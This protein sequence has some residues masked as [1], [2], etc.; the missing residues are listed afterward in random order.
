LKRSWA[1]EVRNVSLLVAIGVS[2]EGQREIRGICEVAKEDKAGWS[3]CLAHLKQRGL[4]RVQLVISDAC[5]GLVE[6][7]AEFYPEALWQRCVVHRNAGTRWSTRRYLD[8]S[9]LPQPQL[10][11]AWLH[12]PPPDKA[13]GAGHCRHGT[14]EHRR[15]RSSKLDRPIAFRVCGGAASPAHRRHRP[16][17]P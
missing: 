4:A 9:P 8:M 10:Q 15:H 5:T 11:A 7:V 6:S 13:K 3:A 16:E 14:C 12:Q 17:L 1:G 2:T